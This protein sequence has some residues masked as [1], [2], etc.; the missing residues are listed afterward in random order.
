MDQ[1][2]MDR[3]ITAHE[4]EI[5]RWMLEHAAVGDV[6]A[7]KALPLEELRVIVPGSTQGLGRR[8]DYR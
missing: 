3:A 4:V 8:H 7:Y 6:A 5:L 1:A 2:A